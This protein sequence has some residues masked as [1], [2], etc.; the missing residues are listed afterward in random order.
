MVQQNKAKEP[1]VV[2]ED[3]K[4]YTDQVRGVIG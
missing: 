1:I 4:S 2:V 3:Y